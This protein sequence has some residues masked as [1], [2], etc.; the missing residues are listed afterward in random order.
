LLIVVEDDG[1]GIPGQRQNE[2]LERGR[3]LDE[4][5]PGSGLGLDIAQ[6]IAGLYRGSITLGRTSGG[7][8]NAQ[9]DLPAA[10]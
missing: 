7:G 10:D 4:E 8:L 5:V 6:D 3:R 1:P 2:V 9:L